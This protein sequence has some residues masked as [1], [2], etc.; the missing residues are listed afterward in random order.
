MFAVSNSHTIQNQNRQI[1][2]RLVLFPYAGG[3]AAS[4]YRDWSNKL[5][6]NIEVHA[7]EFPGARPQVKRATLHESRTSRAIYG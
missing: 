6:S 2:Q 3:A 4:I 7:V 1:T 5:P